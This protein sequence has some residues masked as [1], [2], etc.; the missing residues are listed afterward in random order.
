[1]DGQLVSSNDERENGK[2]KKARTAKV[3][4][5]W[6]VRAEADVPTAATGSERPARKPATRHFEASFKSA[7]RY[8]PEGLFSCPA[9]LPAESNFACVGSNHGASPSSA[10]ALPISRSGRLVPVTVALF[11]IVP[12]RREHALALL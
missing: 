12:K 8:T 9:S 1:M 10:D 5:F 11:T 7:L 6:S 3:T 4:I 2:S